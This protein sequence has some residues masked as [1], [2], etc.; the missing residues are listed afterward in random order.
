MTPLSTD[1]F[2]EPSERTGPSFEALARANRRDLGVAAACFVSTY[3][4]LPVV[5]IPPG[6]DAAVLLETVVYF[7]AVTWL[8]LEARVLARAPFVLLV[9]GA[10]LLAGV[11]AALN[12]VNVNAASYF[13]VLGATFVGAA[14]AHNVERLWWSLLLAVVVGATDIW[15][16]F[17]PHGVTY[18]LT[19][20]ESPLVSLLSVMQPSV[21]TWRH[22]AFIGMTDMV[23][24][25]MFTMIAFLW[26]LDMR[27]N[28]IALTLS[29][30]GTTVVGL[31]GVQ[32]VPALPLMSLSFVVAHWPFIS[33]A[34][35]DAV[36]AAIRT[37]AQAGQDERAP[38]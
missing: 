21:G 13:K 1:E 30:V 18:Q 4:V 15:S 19:R 35:R 31:A 9:A 27:R 38:M 2:Y 25:S 26:G 8:M 10:I 23:F 5:P 3:A 20:S 33:R 37:T 11:A 29:V 17:S 32:F 7:S 24:L 28:A 16:V 22:E 14:I 6:S 34:V 12:G 36:I